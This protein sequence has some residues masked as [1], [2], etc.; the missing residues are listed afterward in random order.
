LISSLKDDACRGC[1]G[2]AEEQRAI[3]LTDKSKVAGLINGSACGDSKLI[4][5]SEIALIRRDSD[6]RDSALRVGSHAEKQRQGGDG[7]H[8]ESDS[9]NAS[10]NACRLASSTNGSGV[11]HPN[12][13]CGELL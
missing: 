6:Q 4:R 13:P 2:G 11:G 8:A 3:F 12:I 1:A 9:S 7:D 10:I 5:Q